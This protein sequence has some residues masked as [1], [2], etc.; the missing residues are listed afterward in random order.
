MCSYPIVGSDLQPLGLPFQ[1]GYP[2]FWC[3]W[4]T[5]EE[6]ELSWAAH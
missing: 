4:A 1:Q 6:E 3:L 2:A 5:L